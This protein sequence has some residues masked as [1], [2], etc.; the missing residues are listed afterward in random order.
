M[1]NINKFPVIILSSPRTGCTSLAYDIFESYPE[2]KLF[3]EPRSVEKDFST[4]NEYIDGKNYLLKVHLL[5]ALR[6]YPTKLFHIIASR[7]AFVI[8]IRR[9]KLLEQI[10][11][12]YIELH[13]D[14]WGYYVT[15]QHTQIQDVIP[16]DDKLV[17]IAISKIL[18]YNKIL[19]DCIYNFD[20]DLYY[21]DLSF[22][23]KQLIVTPKPI[24]YVE[25]IDYIKERLPKSCLEY[26]SE[27]TKR[28]E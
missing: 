22:D 23:N 21:E 3:N 14:I 19:N 6:H 9:Y 20:L 24:N 11:S 1:Y 2:L 4:F 5:D 17:V 7:N 16:I 27:F 26:N 25:I 28:K 18:Q 12:Y 13:R 8:R 15:G 10:T